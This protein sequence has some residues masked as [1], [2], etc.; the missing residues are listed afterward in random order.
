[1]EEERGE[2]LA[3]RVPRQRACQGLSED[4]IQTQAGP[5]Q[6]GP[7]QA[8]VT[9]LTLGETIHLACMGRPTVG[10][11]KQCRSHDTH[12]GIHAHKDTR[13]TCAHTHVCACI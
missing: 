7:G 9:S 13:C 11:E 12:T 2:R 8:A 1:M 4:G 6:E 10:G 5:G 3:W